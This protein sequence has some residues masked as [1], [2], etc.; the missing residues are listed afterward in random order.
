MSGAF[1]S[2]W[3]VGY[4]A[5]F[6]AAA[7]T[8]V[9]A[10]ALLMIARLS[11]ARWI[12]PFRRQA[13]AVASVCPAFL[14]AFLPLAWCARATP[15]LV[16]R[17]YVYLFSWSALW[18]G[19]RHP[20]ATRIASAAGVPLLMLT[21]SFAGFDWMMALTPHWVSDA[22]GLYVMTGAFAG[23]V[24]LLASLSGASRNAANQGGSAITPERSLALGSVLLTGVILW[25]YIAFCQFL[26]IWI[27]DLPAEIP[28]YA[29]RIDGAWKWLLV[30]S[31]ISQF[32]FP[33]LLLLSRE[34]KRHPARVAAVGAIA[35]AGHF[36]D[37]VW[38]A[39][40]AASPSLS[41]LAFATA[42]GMFALFVAYCARPYEVT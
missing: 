40:P 8:S 29:D 10:L 15:A 1:L 24:G 12:D 20:K 3:L 34:L 13:E 25:A 16:V 11:G 27:G 18:L 6:F 37:V 32:V 39:L 26:I 41:L 2:P 23:G 5:G 21:V 19:W 9:G 7:S 30:A 14:V 35:V 38:I 22:F 28:F 36:L 33:F 17:S 4:L 31:V 42:L